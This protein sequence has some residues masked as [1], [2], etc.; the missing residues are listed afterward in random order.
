MTMTRPRPPKFIEH[1]K[2]YGLR[3]GQ[4]RRI[5]RFKPGQNNQPGIVWC[6]YCDTS[7]LESVTVCP[8][9]STVFTDASPE[10]IERLAGYKIYVRQNPD[11]AAALLGKKDDEIA[12]LK[13]Q[14]DGF[15]RSVATLTERVRLAEQ[16]PA[17]EAAGDTPAGPAQPPASEFSEGED[18]ASRETVGG[19]VRRPKAPKPPK[20]PKR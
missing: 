16:R 7:M 10:T 12:G 20:P 1:P 5:T 15:E 4:F 14:V 8:K 2:L 13:V 19:D 9:C 11:A 18:P 6:P 17:P 3:D